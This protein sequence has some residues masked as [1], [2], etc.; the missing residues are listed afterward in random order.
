MPQQRNESEAIRNLQ[1][2]LRQLSYR[3]KITP[4]PVDGIFESNTRR[5]L[6][7]FQELYGL[8]VSGSA[9]RDTWDAL[10]AAYRA[11]ITENTPPHAVLILP[12][13]S[14]TFPLKSGSRGLPVNVL[15]H[16]L[17]E[18][19]SL[20]SALE[21]V[22]VTGEYDDATA[23]AVRELQGRNR[24]EVTGTVDIPTWNAITDQYNVL[25]STEPLQ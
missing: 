8:P 15:Q 4:P 23:D 24:L 14:N 3:E 6:E 7:E 2:Y 17:V 25:F 13:S 22:T 12:P 9:N 21:G 5:A 20:Y 11:S 18:L 1:R 16:M 19:S 10:Y